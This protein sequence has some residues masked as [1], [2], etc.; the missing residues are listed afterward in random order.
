MLYLL[1][2]KAHAYVYPNNGCRRWDTAGP[3]AV[4]RAV[5]GEL[6]DVYGDKYL[7]TKN[8]ERE[9]KDEFGIFATAPE[10]DHDDFMVCIK[11]NAENTKDVPFW[12]QGD[13]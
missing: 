4:L 12:D 1:E 10:V 11:G 6:T 7:Y 2:G 9:P 8:Y 5:G 13:E 3:E